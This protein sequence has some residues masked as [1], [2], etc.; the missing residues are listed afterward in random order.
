M[1]TGDHRKAREIAAIYD[2]AWIW[3]LVK[4][5]DLRQME[6]GSADCMRAARYVV[7]YEYKGSYMYIGLL[8]GQYYVLLS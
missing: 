6:Q 2:K 1:K 5:W 8:Y 3:V 7:P 4:G